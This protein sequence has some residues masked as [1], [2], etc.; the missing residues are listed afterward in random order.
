MSVRADLYQRVFELAP[1][2]MALVSPTGQWLR[3]N[4]AACALLGR[5]AEDLLAL[6]DEGLT[7][8]ES[9]GLEVYQLRRLLAGEVETCSFEK[10]CLHG[11]GH[12]LWIRHDVSRVR[13]DEGEVAHL[14]VQLQDI[15]E[16]VQCEESE[17]ASRDRLQHLLSLSP[18]VV[19]SSEATGDFALTFVSGN[20]ASILGYEPRDLI[21][22]P[23]LWLDRIHPDDVARVREGLRLLDRAG[24][25]EH[26]YRFQHGDGSYRWLH[27]HLRFV[28]DPRGHTDE[29]VG[30]WED[31]SER[32]EG[33]A[34]LQRAIEAARRANGELTE[35]NRHLES[36]TL[37]AKEMAMQAEMAAAAK[38]EFLA[39]MSHEIRTPMNGIMGMTS[40]LLDTEMDEEQREFAQS[41][42]SCADHLLTLINDILD[43]S[44]IEAGKMEMESID[45]DL[46][47]T[48]E[49]VISVLGPRAA[50]RGL[51]LGC[52]IHPEIPS[53]LRGDPGR[54]RQ[55][56]INLVGNAIKFTEEGEVLVQLHLKEE[57]S[58]GVVICF[59]VH[60]TGMGIPQDRVPRLFQSFSQVDA[61]VTRKHG[62]TGLGLA[63]SKQLTQMMGGDI[64]VVSEVGQGST[65]WFTATFQHQC[66][67]E[68]EIPLEG[69]EGKRILVVGHTAGGGRSLPEQLK[70]WGCRVD[71]AADAETALKMMQR[72]VSEG[73]PIDVGIVDMQVPGRDVE[74]LGVLMRN[75]KSLPETPLVLLR[76]IGQRG[77]AAEAAERGF[78][79]YLTRPLKP[80]L[81]HDCLATLIGRVRTH[82]RPI[83]ETPLVTRHSLAEDQRHRLRILLA[84]DNPVNQR[85]ALRLLA[86]LG[87]HAKAVE[88]GRQALEVLER[89]PMD[90]LLTDIQMPEMDG[91]RLTAEIRHRESGSDHRLPIIAM[92]AHAMK[93][94]REACLDAGMDDYLTKPVKPEALAEAIGR[95]LHV[96]LERRAKPLSPVSPSSA[97]EMV[98]LGLPHP[99]L[100]G[101]TIL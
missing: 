26:E 46:R 45:F 87:L 67:E 28:R 10:R 58:D 60:D 64:G 25:L 38:G 31:V 35:V 79:G 99:S 80:S 3:V 75:V 20:A 7:H 6:G 88:N 42:W 94:D 77:E 39:N 97:A 62:G 33:E 34:D 41:V 69:L 47:S 19:H 74:N 96:C 85:V 82:A 37:L 55:I 36:T 101:K 43:F 84:E 54:L 59:Q 89:E 32:R 21:N 92:T 63:I 83:A 23:T 53:R 14:I 100:T 22:S 9:W 30:C 15:T 93:G 12:G 66:A 71:R 27:D 91:M 18:A 65:F 61:S 11:D 78:R 48:V 8:P 16:K 40:L 90:L 68:R 49:D 95:W 17:E 70:L 13:D 72:A 57:R 81:L 76:S 56:L 51:E 73:Q 86:K 44:K 52:L 5:P 4:R 1:I 98:S 24:S 2:G 50:E 29:I